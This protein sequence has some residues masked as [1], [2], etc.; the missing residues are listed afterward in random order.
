MITSSSNMP[1]LHEI[2][3]VFDPHELIAELLGDHPIANVHRSWPG[4]RIARNYACAH[5]GLKPM[6]RVARWSLEN[7]NWGMLCRIMVQHKIDCDK[8]IERALIATDPFVAADMWEERGKLTLARA[9]RKYYA[10]KIDYDA[11]TT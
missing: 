8:W 6:D 10:G 11:A 4:W 5:R 9:M 1:L 2:L 3:N 7:D